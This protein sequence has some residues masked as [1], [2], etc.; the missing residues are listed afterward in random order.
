[1]R[2]TAACFC[3]ALHVQLY[4][5]HHGGFAAFSGT[6]ATLPPQQQVA[7]LRCRVCLFPAGYLEYRLRLHMLV[8]G[9]PQQPK[10]E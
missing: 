4:R 9:P 1:M 2:S 10:D 6:T 3:A 7:Y 8:G 5:D